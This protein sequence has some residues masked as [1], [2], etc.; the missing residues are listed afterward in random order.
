MSAHDHQQVIEVM[1]D[2]P[3]NWPSASIFLRCIN[4]SRAASSR[5]CAC[6]RFGDVAGDLG[7]ADQ[8]G[9]VRHGSDR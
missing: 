6:R 1:G 9:F 7:E 8:C 4:C 3:V 5:S 2:S